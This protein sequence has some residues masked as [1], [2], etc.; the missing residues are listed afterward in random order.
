MHWLTFLLKVHRSNLNRCLWISP[1]F[2]SPLLFHSLCKFLYHPFVKCKWCRS[3]L[4][5]FETITQV[6]PGLQMFYTMFEISS[7]RIVALCFS[8]LLTQLSVWQPAIVSVFVEWS[9]ILEKLSGDTSPCS[10]FL[11]W[12]TGEAYAL[13]HFQNLALFQ[14]SKVFIK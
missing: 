1:I 7:D 3:F 11:R 5:C 13:K 14:I 4:C 6:F 12:M 8:F 9:Y 2:L 10:D